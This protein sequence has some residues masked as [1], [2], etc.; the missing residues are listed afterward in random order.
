LAQ[1]G[2]VIIKYFVSELN[3]PAEVSVLNL[4]TNYQTTAALTATAA[5]DT[6]KILSDH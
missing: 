5:A 4:A 1:S 6:S 3:T 2:S